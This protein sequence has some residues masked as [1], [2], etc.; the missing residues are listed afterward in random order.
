MLICLLSQP[1]KLG[2]QNPDSKTLFWHS[3]HWSFY[4]FGENICPP[5]IRL[6]VRALEHHG[7][8][9]KQRNHI[10]A[11]F[12]QCINKKIF[13]ACGAI[14]WWKYWRQNVHI[15][16]QTLG[17]MGHLISHFRSHFQKMKTVFIFR[18]WPFLITLNEFLKNSNQLQMHSH[19]LKLGS[20]MPLQHS[21][22]TCA[23]R[24]SRQRGR[25]AA[26]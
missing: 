4:Q 8:A 21:A 9:R 17:R 20:S 6:G 10:L 23:A 14:L 2:H 25:W 26:F 18:R 13:L 7:G 1:S 3:R 5:W 15:S 11:K 22:R 16:P 12:C 19:F 24:Y